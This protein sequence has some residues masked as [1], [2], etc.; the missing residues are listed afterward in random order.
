MRFLVIIA[1]S[2]IL[3]GIA[4]FITAGIAVGQGE[5]IETVTITIRDGEQGPPGPAGPAG[6]AGPP[7]ATTCRTG[8][9]LKDLQI[10]APGG[11][12]TLTDVCIQN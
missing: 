11:Q 6:P 3:A 4:G 12:I 10:N 8:S 7:G 2:L 1:S 5:P 9:T